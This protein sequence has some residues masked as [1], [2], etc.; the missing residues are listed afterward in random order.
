M[1]TEE[2]VKTEVKR[3]VAYACSCPLSPW[4]AV[5]WPP[6][7]PHLGLEGRWVPDNKHIMGQVFVPAFVESLAARQAIGSGCTP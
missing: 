1:T 2:F 6:K 4:I 3:W 7:G 5:G